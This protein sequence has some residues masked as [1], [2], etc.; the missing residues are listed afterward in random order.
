MTA[1]ITREFLNVAEVLH[2]ISHKEALACRKELS[3]IESKAYNA[4]ELEAENKR[5]KK[6]SQANTLY[7]ISLFT[8]IAP[9]CEPLQELS[10]V[11]CQIDNWCSGKM[12]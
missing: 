8:A 10:G 2:G 3:E 6:E 7:A 9:Q 4:I 11:L 1:K 12:Q 5:L